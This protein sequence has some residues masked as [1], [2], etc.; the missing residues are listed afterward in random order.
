MYSISE[1]AIPDVVIKTSLRGEEEEE[2][3]EEEEEEEEGQRK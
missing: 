2:K 3:E 1:T